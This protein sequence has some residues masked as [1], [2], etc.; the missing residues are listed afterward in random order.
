MRISLLAA[1]LIACSSFAGTASAVQKPDTS[2]FLNHL[3]ESGHAYAGMIIYRYYQLQ[4]LRI[5]DLTFPKDNIYETGFMRF[6]D[7]KGSYINLAMVPPNSHNIS[8]MNSYLHK[9]VLL[10]RDPRQA[11]I[12]WIDYTERQTQYH[13]ETLAKIYPPPPAEYWKW[14]PAQKA[15]WQIDHFY[16][17]SIQWLQ[18]WMASMDKNPNLTVLPVT[19]EMM[20]ADPLAFF[21]NIIHFY[22]GDGSLFTDKDL[23]PMT[24]EQF[25]FV[26][27]DIDTWRTRLTSAQQARVNSMLSDTVLHRFGWKR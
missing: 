12:S 26:P 3:P 6:I 9:I 22:G 23:L 25:Y 16:T 10:L 27:T 7:G 24:R 18:D 19:F 5:S 1:L 13:S 8:W 17:Y 14:T 11:L 21:R 2:I 15:D 4:P 20:V